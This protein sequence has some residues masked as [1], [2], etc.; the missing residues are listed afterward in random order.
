MK[1]IFTLF[2]V[3]LFHLL[4]AQ[5]YTPTD[6][7]SEVGFTIRNFG[8]NVRGT[9]AGL[10]GDIQFDEAHLSSA[11]F[12]VSIK[13]NTINTGIKRRDNHLNQ[14][15]F[16]DTEKFSTLQF[17]SEKI[18]PSTDKDHWFVFGKLTIKD[19]T[20]EI[21][22]PFKAVKTNNDYVFEGNFTVN[23]RDFNVGGGSIS[24]ADEL[25]VSLKIH[26]KAK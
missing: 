4:H 25:T 20:R 15:E 14:E 7:G 9:F 5:H 8:V 16:L 1:L 11:S 19:V 2:F 23:R 6:E 18:T 24:M 21:S 26:A 13:A 10:E 12:R 3:L 17:I 22:F